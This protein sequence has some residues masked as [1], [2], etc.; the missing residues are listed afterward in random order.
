[1]DAAGGRGL[2][3]INVC[4]GVDPDDIH[5]PAEPLADGTGS[6]GNR[7]NGDG[8]VTTE[9]EGET[10]LFGVFVDLGGETFGDGGNREGVVHAVLRGVF[11]GED[12]GVVVDLAVIVKVV[13]EGIPEVI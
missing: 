1:M 4:V 8:V 6:T 5:G 7:A 3:G 2:R 10:A 9:S 13:P 11:F 12:V